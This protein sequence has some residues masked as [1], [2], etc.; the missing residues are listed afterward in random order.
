MALAGVPGVIF[1]ALAVV[2]GVFFA[3][4]AMIAFVIARFPVLDHAIAI[5][6]AAYFVFWAVGGTNWTGVLLIVTV[7]CAAL[8][9]TKL[10]R[11]AGRRFWGRP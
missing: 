11:T 4:V 8:A 7:F 5:V 10:R 3:L 1:A 2:I 6:L 9:F